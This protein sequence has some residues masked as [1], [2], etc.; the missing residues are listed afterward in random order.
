M[1]N[2]NKINEFTAFLI[3]DLIDLN[4]SAQQSDECEAW[5]LGYH[6][7]VDEA[8]RIVAEMFAQYKV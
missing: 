8:L 7:A 5:K 2:N 6:E 4:I 1:E 3:T